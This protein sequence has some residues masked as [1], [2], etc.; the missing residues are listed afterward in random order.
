MTTSRLPGPPGIFTGLPNA[1]I[2]LNADAGVEL[3]KGQWRY[4]DAEVVTVD[5]PH[6]ANDANVIDHAADVGK[7]IADLDATF[8]VSFELPGRSKEFSGLSKLYAWF[9]KRELPAIV[10]LQRGLVV[11]SINVRRAAFHEQK[12]YSLR[13]WS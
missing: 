2:E 7:Q 12:D 9:G 1:S 13:A 3:V 10:T 8:T 11:K 5:I 6:R 4:H